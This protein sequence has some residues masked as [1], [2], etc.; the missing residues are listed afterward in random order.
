[1]IRTY[2]DDVDSFSDP[3]TQTRRQ[4]IQLLKWLK[5]QR[6]KPCPIETLVSIGDPSTLLETNPGMHKIFEKILQAEQ[7]P[8]RIV[9][10]EKEQKEKLLTPYMIQKISDLIV[11]EQ[12]QYKSKQFNILERY[13]LTSSDLTLGVR[14][15][16]CH[17]IPMQ[18]IHGSWYCPQCRQVNKLA[19]QETIKDHLYLHETISNKECRQLLHLESINAT[20]RLLRKM[21]LS[22]KGA[23]K[24]IT[25]SLPFS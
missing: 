8:E 23:A 1:M 24:A 17:H 20:T 21:N 15:L 2:K 13:S 5:E 19:H 3:V 22:Q 10:L 25:Y 16:T 11:Q 18:R 12:Q 4:K 9:Q 7:I 14:C 6:I